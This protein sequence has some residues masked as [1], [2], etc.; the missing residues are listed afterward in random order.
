MMNLEQYL[1]CKLSEE[2]SEI[3]QIAMKTQQF[4]VHEVCPDQPY[5]N[6]ERIHQEIDDLIAVVDLLNEIGLDYNRSEDR[7]ENKKVKMLKYLRIASDLD[8]V[9]TQAPLEYKTLMVKSNSENA[10]NGIVFEGL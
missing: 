5:T 1:L 10:C 8:Q 2:S 6:A 7:I 9:D 4:G 3:G